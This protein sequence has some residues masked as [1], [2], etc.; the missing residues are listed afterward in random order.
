MPADQPILQMRVVITAPEYERLVTFYR[1]TLGLQQLD[2]FTEHG[3]GVV[4]DCGRATLEILDE[5]HSAWVDTV[6][7]GQ[8]GDGAVRLALEVTDTEAVTSRL[9][10][11]GAEVIGAVATT[12]W[13]SE[14][15]RVVDPTG[16]QLTI[17]TEPR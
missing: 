1:D 3:R 6:E 12:P 9:A 15:S 17:F 4:L 14:N 2:T 8:P 10:A 7:T 13:E 5:S 16:L 11:A